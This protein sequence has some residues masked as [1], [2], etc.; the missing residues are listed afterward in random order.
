MLVSVEVLAEAILVQVRL[1][2]ENFLRNLLVFTFDSLQLS[3]PLVKVK[4]LCFEFNCS[5]GVA[6]GEST[7]L[8]SRQV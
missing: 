6:L 4:T 5:N 2:A 1:Q 8:M 7:A 3:L